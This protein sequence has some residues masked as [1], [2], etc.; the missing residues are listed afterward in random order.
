MMKIRSI[1][2]FCYRAL[3]DLFPL[4]FYNA[5][6]TVSFLFYQLLVIIT[7]ITHVNIFNIRNIKVKFEVI[8][9]RDDCFLLQLFFTDFSYFPL[10]IVFQKFLDTVRTF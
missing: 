3:K 5:L 8:V 10:K 2:S 9:N 6:V 4:N 1:M 7:I